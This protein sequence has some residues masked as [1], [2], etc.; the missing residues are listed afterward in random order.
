MVTRVHRVETPD[1]KGPRTEQAAAR[2]ITLMTGAASV[3]AVVVGLVPWLGAGPATAHEDHVGVARAPGHQGVGSRAAP[4]ELPPLLLPNLRSVR[5][6]DFSIEMRNG[7]RWLRFESAL[8]NAGRGPLETRPDQRARCPRGQQHASQVIYR[9][10][11]GSGWYRRQVD[12][13][14]RIRSAGC[15]V[16]HPAHDHWHFDAASRY[17]L[18][19]ADAERAVS[20]HR[21]TS[22]CLRDSRRAPVPWG[23]ARRY[24]SHYGAC[25]VDN[26]QGIM[27][28][29]ADVYQSF[30]PGQ[31]L[32]LP[33]GMP[34]GRY[35]VRVTVDPL[36]QLW[37][38]DDTD[39]SSVRA[40][41]IRNRVV[42]P[43]AVG[44][45]R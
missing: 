34:N 44:A 38:T 22:F 26:P 32:Q 33:E 8:G 2:R 25:D 29:W 15:M 5:P 6:R 42:D 18:F 3:I 27:I 24:E 35:C 39:N 4:D 37:E 1:P 9:D 28:G 41:R 13:R 23:A 31:A 40:V 11:D 14:K 16:F 19:P 36:D 10:V 43:I 20:R 7:H 30:L 21:K 17:S 12:I 45:C